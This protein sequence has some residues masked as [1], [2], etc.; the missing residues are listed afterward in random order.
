[1]CILVEKA[2]SFCQRSPEALSLELFFDGLNKKRTPPPVSHKFVDCFDEL[3][4]ED[5]VSSNCLFS[6][7]RYLLIAKKLPTVYDKAMCETSPTDM[8]HC[9]GVNFDQV[10]FQLDDDAYEEFSHLLDAPPQPSCALRAL[11]EAQPPWERLD[12]GE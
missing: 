1:M 5:D 10:E 12:N 6:H 2:P 9:N 7:D 11:L 4:G 8:T 3:P